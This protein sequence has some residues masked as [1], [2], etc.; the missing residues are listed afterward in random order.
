MSN[1]R[2]LLL[3]AVI[4]YT[5]CVPCVTRV[6]HAQDEPSQDE[7]AIEQESSTGFSSHVSYRAGQPQK[8]LIKRPGDRNVT[9]SPAQRYL[10]SDNV[11]AGCPE[12]LGVLAAPSSSSKYS[13]GYAGGSTVLNATYS[14][15]RNH[16][17]GTWGLD[18]TLWGH[19]KLAWLRWSDGSRS[20]PNGNFETD[21]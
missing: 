9:S 18:F 3:I 8:P 11:R 7:P 17:E 12:S 19:P 20:Q 5:M 1:L 21:R 6:A 4:Q 15:P 16:Q 13:A 2:F 10:Q 14:R